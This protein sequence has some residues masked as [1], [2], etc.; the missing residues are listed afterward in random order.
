MSTATIPGA[1]QSRNSPSEQIVGLIIATIKNDKGVHAE[2]AIA[3]AAVLTGEYVLRAAGH[4]FAGVEPGSV[5]L[6]DKV[7]ELLFESDAQMTI[8]DYFFNALYSQ[9]IDV[10]KDSWPDSIP[11]EH[12]VMFDPM[13]VAA[14]MRGEIGK[15]LSELPNTLECAY[16]CAGATALL[17]AQTRRVLDPNIGKAL[18]L[19]A[20]LRGAKTAPL[21]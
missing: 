9:G 14:R 12:N 10:N 15:L 1:G 3:T 8:S 7:N 5:I 2:S 19:E 6:S 16:A 18:A 17:V 20:M 11:D 13:E 21:A 4:D